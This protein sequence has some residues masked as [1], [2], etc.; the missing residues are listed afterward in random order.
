TS[1][2][3]SLL[4]LALSSCCCLHRLCSRV[5]RGMP[6]ALTLGPTSKPDDASQASRTQATTSSVPACT[7]RLRMC[8]NSRDAL[9][10]ERKNG[11]SCR[12]KDL[13]L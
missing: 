10:C 13:G 7:T 4:S 3:M 1:Y 5:S 6:L 9:K 11:A 8:S 2:F 12:S